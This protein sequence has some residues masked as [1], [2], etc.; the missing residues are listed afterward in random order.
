MAHICQVQAIVFYSALCWPMLGPGATAMNQ[1]WHSR[2]PRPSGR[3]TAPGGKGQTQEGTKNAEVSK[4]HRCHY[5]MPRPPDL[6]PILPPNI[7]FSTTLFIVELSQ[8][9]GEMI[10]R[11]YFQYPSGN[12]NPQALIL[13]SELRCSG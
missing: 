12:L 8:H 4:G 11:R 13:D 7:V 10:L 9:L 3:W 5:K 1:Q 6:M 2:C